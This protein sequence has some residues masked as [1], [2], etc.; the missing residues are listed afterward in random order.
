MATEQRVA[1][2]QAKHAEVDKQILDIENGAS[3]D[4][5]EVSRLKALKLSIKD[6]IEKLRS[7]EQCSGKC[8][9]GCE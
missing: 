4:P 6:E 3:T 9:C 7:G 8:K 2:L 1:A 5:A